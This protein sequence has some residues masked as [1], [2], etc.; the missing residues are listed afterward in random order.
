M[1]ETFAQGYALLIGVGQSAYAPWSL[2]VTVKDARAIRAVLTDPS[3]CAY[4]DDHIR[5]LHDE[6]ATC[7]AILEGLDWLAQRV[8]AEPRATAV[9]YFSGHG[10]L[11]EPAGRYFLIPHDVE[12]HDIPGSALPAAE[13]I[14]ALRRVKAERLLAIIDACHA[15]GMAA[16]KE[17]S[18]ALELPAGLVPAPPPKMVVDALKQGAGRAVFTSS[19]GHQKSWVRPDGTMSV[20]TYHLIEALQGANN[21]PGETTVKISNLMNYLGKAVPESARTLCNAEQTPVSDFTAAEDFAVA[22]LRGGKGL[23]AG[24]WPSVEEES[25]VTIGR[26]VQ[27]IGERSVAIGGNVSGSVVITGD[28]NRVSSAGADRVDARFRGTRPRSHE[29]RSRLV[30]RAEKGHALDAESG[31]VGSLAPRLSRLVRHEP[32]SCRSVRSGGG[33]FRRAR[34]HGRRPLWPM[35][36]LDPHVAPIRLGRLS[37]VEAMAHLDRRPASRRRAGRT[38]PRR[39]LGGPPGRAGAGAEGRRAGRA[40]VYLHGYNVSFDEAAIRAAQIGFDLKVPGAMAFFSWP[41]RGALGGYAAD[42]ASIEASEAAIADFLVR[43][44]TDSRASRVHVIAHSM[45]NRGLLRAIQR[46]MAQASATAG[47]RFGQVLLAAPD[48]DAGH[49]RNLAALYPRVSERTTLYVSAGD[50][51]LEASRRLH[52]FDRV[53]Y[54]PPITVVDGIDTVE[55][56]GL[57]LSLLGHRDFAEVHGALYD[58]HQLLQAAMPAPDSPRLHAMQVTPTDERS[59]GGRLRPLRGSRKQGD[60]GTR[61]ALHD[62]VGMAKPMRRG[63]PQSTVTRNIQRPFSIGDP[64]K[65]SNR[66]RSSSRP[67]SIP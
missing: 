24:G 23:P 21:R 26:I 6:Q 55:V 50:R 19:R 30:E 18:D 42:E 64:C 35:S 38:R 11:E 47:V 44:A 29:R 1:A 17:R 36:G 15:E 54:A 31:A 51:A 3:L 63:C 39:V 27:A 20:Y 37:L 14:E 46:I 4:P 60:A 67:P 8:A 10:W 16:A 45:G 28:G 5:L 61:L 41:S 9:V 57:D 34:E 7:H 48:L 13:F 53:G 32:P 62:H 58:M 33:L 65:P 59:A 40:L 56:S 66:C 2:P 43:L 22:M 25:R 12:P 52:R 49:F